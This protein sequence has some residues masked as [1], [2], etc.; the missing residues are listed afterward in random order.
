MYYDDGQ[1]SD[2]VMSKRG[3]ARDMRIRAP[4]PVLLD[5]FTRGGEFLHIRVEEAPDQEQIG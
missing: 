4:S 3:M 2:I 1:V 5:A